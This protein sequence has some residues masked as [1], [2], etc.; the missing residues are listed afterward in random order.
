MSCR[1]NEYGNN[2]IKFDKSIKLNSAKKIGKYLVAF[3][4]FVQQ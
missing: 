3:G 1:V 4:P 2:P